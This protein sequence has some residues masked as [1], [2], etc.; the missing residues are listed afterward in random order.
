MSLQLS[1]PLTLADK[2]RQETNAF[3]SDDG[4]S[5]VESLYRCLL[6]KAQSASCSGNYSVDFY[7]HLLENKSFANALKG[8][9]ERDGF[10]VAIQKDKEYSKHAN[11]TKMFVRISWR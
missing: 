1:V 5:K 3:H 10:S 6:V 4:R 2:L 8:K 11:D 9:L 7:C